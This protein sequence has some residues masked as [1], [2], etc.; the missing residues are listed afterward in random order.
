MTRSSQQGLVVGI[1]IFLGIVTGGIAQA[2]G[3]D[4]WPSVIIA[5]IAGVVFVGIGM[6][7]RRSSST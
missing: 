1:G 4:R 5:G 3:A 6:V 7:V 2:F